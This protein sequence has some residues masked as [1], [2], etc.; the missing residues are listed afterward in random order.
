[1]DE[2]LTVTNGN[3]QS[4]HVVAGRQV[5]TRE[6]LEVL[7]LATTAEVADGGDILET[8]ER[9]AAAGGIPVLAWA[10]GKWLGRRGRR[11]HAILSE[12]QP[13]G[14]LIGD[15]AM[16]PRG[17]PT[18]RLMLEA[19]RRGFAIV[20]GTDPLPLAGEESLIGRYGIAAD[21]VNGAAT[22]IADLRALL[23]DGRVAVTGR[24]A[25]P[26]D[27]AARWLRLR[28]ASRPRHIDP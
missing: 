9:I 27:A 7:A 5:A 2:V 22:M 4:V 19:K 17:W 8:V 26:G 24:R 3:G 25:S 23:A 21:G 1:V 6:R 28:L 16:R 20:A 18:P 14:L 10:P 11:V 12:V 15:T 13:G